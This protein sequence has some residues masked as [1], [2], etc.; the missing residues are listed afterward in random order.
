[1]ARHK[2][3][4]ETEA[5]EAAMHTFWSRGYQGT[6]LQDLEAAMNLT[7]T[8]IY[9]AYG[10]KRQ[11]FDKS[12]IHYQQTVLSRMFALLN[13]GHTL[14]EGI[15]K[16]LNGVLDMHFDSDTPGGCLVVL[17]ILEREQHDPA[18][19][20]V[21]ENIIHQMQKGLQ[22]RIAAAQ[23]AG[24]LDSEP[25]ARSLA[26]TVATTMAG[27]VV[28]ANAGFKKPLLRKVVNT[29]CTLLQSG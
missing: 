11:L 20:Q 6:S 19:I 2:E 5:L 4:D 10:N 8:S 25:D 9:N 26:A 12:V 13:S 3:F 18:S 14:Q 17:S 16:M 29:S 28:M 21:L 15:R 27:L 23:K 22:V 24:E 7:R 1:M